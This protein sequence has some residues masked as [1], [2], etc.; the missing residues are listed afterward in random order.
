MAA[1]LIGKKIGM[2]RISNDQGVFVPVTAIAIGKN[3]V[4][5]VKSLDKDGKNAVVL[6]SN[7]YKKPTKTQKYKNIK[8]FVVDDSGSYEK[9]KMLGCE[10]LENVDVV[11]ISS[12]SKGKGFQGVMKRWNFAGGPGSHGSHFH[13]EPGSIGSR[14]RPGKVMKGKK[15][16][17]HM[18][19]DRITFRKKEII[20]LDTKNNIVFVKGPV[21]GSRNSMVEIVF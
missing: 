14:E 5:Y 12:V 2:T 17:G 15:L 4:L 9:G 7:P 8:E 20:S 6:G 11:R 10:L 3:E 16:P 19:V 13:R 18:G 1:G 21:A